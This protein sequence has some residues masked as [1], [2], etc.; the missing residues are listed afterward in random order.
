VVV[1][2]VTYH[3]EV[4]LVDGGGLG[5]YTHAHVVQR[6][7]HRGTADTEEHTLHPGQRAKHSE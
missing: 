1:K 5:Q 2:G 6:L 7:L 3:V 4:D